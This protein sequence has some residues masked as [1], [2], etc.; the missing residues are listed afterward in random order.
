[1]ELFKS[2]LNYD[3]NTGLFTWKRS[4]NVAGTV[5]KDGY[6]QLC[7]GRNYELAHRVAWYIVNGEVPKMIDHINGI[8][9]DNRITNLRNVGMYENGRNRQ[10]LNS[11]NSSGVDGVSFHKLRGKWRARY[12]VY[13]KMHHVG[14][15]DTKEEAT[16]ALNQ[17][18][19]GGQNAV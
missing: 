11:N 4:G 12:I 16:E 3:P 1:M 14:T 10:Y 9:G 15:F 2:R 5:R 7:V 18:R 8:P 17:H 19:K 13:G 6:V